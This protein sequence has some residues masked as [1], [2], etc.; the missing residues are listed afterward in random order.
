MKDGPGKSPFYK[1]ILVLEK[2]LFA[3]WFVPGKSPCK[4]VLVLE[5]SFLQ[6]DFGPGKHRFCKVVLVLEKALFARWVAW[7]WRGDSPQQ[8]L[9]C[10]CG[11]RALDFS[12][13]LTVMCVSGDT[14]EWNEKNRHCF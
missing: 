10:S 6:G 8:V 9:L 13:Q 5:K 14:L 4:V 1:V 2:V 12:V 3:R 11:K 7:C